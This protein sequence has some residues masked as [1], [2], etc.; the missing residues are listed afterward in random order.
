M[1]KLILD[2]SELEHLR[3]NGY[4][5]DDIRRLKSKVT[6]NLTNTIYGIDRRDSEFRLKH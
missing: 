6:W 1:S 3:R 2:K 4:A 5:N